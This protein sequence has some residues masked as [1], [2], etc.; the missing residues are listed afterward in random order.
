M[1]ISYQAGEMLQ[2]VLLVFALDSDGAETRRKS[3]PVLRQARMSTYCC[4]FVHAFDDPEAG[5]IMYTSNDCNPYLKYKTNQ[6]NPQSINI[7]LT[8]VAERTELYP[9][10][11]D[12]ALE[13]T[14]AADRFL[15]HGRLQCP[16]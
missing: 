11:A 16:T 1:K 4:R 12:D 8:S 9:V 14:P 7:N 10:A 5:E 3:C 13:R 15:S 2:H 6:H